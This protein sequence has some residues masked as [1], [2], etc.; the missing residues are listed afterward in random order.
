MVAWWIEGRDDQDAEF[1]PTEHTE[2][3]EESENK[4][5]MFH[6]WIMPKVNKKPDTEPSS[7]KVILQLRPVLIGEF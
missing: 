3:T 7:V 1:L 5:L 2:Y 4:S 6:F